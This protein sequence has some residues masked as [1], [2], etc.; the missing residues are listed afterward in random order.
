M[1][2]P[3]FA[4]GYNKFRQAKAWLQATQAW[5]T[6]RALSSAARDYVR[7]KAT[8]ASLRTDRA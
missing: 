4:W 7:H 3:A 2:I 5:R 1:K 6:M 8:F